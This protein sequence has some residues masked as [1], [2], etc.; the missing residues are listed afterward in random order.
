MASLF[1]NVVNNNNLSSPASSITGLKKNHNFNN[2]DKVNKARMLIIGYLSPQLSLSN[3][4]AEDQEAGDNKKN[5]SV[6]CSD[7]GRHSFE[8][9]EEEEK[10]EEDV[11]NDITSCDISLGKNNHLFPQ[12]FTF[13]NKEGSNMTGIISF[14][15]IN[16]PY[17]LHC[18]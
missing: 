4:N 5:K 18:Y 8:G 3:D 13:D 7:K 15:F 10:K 12:E 16:F 1:E 14:L 6:V 17:L 11:M 2:S 9:T